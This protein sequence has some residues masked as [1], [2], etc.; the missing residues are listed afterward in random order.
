[1]GIKS[2]IF[3]LFIFCFSSGISLKAQDSGDTLKPLRNLPELQKPTIALGTGMLSFKGDVSSNS[4][5]QNLVNRIAYDLTLSKPL[6]SFLDLNFYILFGKIG[7]NERTASRNLNFQSEIRSGGLTLLYNFDHLLI[8]N[9]KIEPYILFGFEGFEFLSKTDMYDKNGNMYHYWDDGSIRS[10]AQNSPNA[11]KAIVL[12]RDYSYESDIRELDMD[13]FGKYKEASYAI[14]IG[15]GAKMKL[16]DRVNFK[17]GPTFHF[18]MTDYIDGITDLSI[19]DRKGNKRNDVFI[20]TSFSLSYDLVISKGLPAQFEEGAPEQ[21]FEDVDYLALYTADEDIDGVRDFIDKCAGTPPGVKVD[22]YGCPLDEDNDGIPN[23]KDDELTTPKDVFV[24]QN[25][26]ELTDEL[27]EQ[28]YRAYLGYIQPLDYVQN[29]QVKRETI[30]AVQVGVYKD[31]KVP[32]EM[33]D[34]LLNIPDVKSVSLPDNSTAFIV[35]EFKNPNNAENRKNIMQE[36]GIADAKIVEIQINEKTNTTK[37]IPVDENKLAANIMNNING[38][39]NSTANKTNNTTS[40]E[41]KNYAADILNTHSKEVG[42]NALL[43]SSDKVE[44]KVMLGAY[45]KGIPPTLIN[46]FLKVPNIS[47]DK[48]NDSITVYTVGKYN[49]LA[50]AINKQ[51]EITTEGISDAK[52][53]QFINGKYVPIT[54][55]QIADLIRKGDKIDKL[56]TKYLSS[57][58]KQIGSNDLDI[59]EYYD[60]SFAN[61]DPRDVV[62]FRVQLGAYRKKLSRNIFKGVSGVIELT[63]EEKLTKYLTGSFV[64]YNDAARHKIDMLEKGFDDAFIVAYKNG[65]RVPLNT[66]GATNSAP[67]NMEENVPIN[68]VNKDLISYKIEIGT[69]PGDLPADML[70]KLGPL[71]LD[72]EKQITMEGNKRYTVGSFS[73]YMSA[74]IFKNQI[75]K[76]YNLSQVNVIAFFKD[77]MIPLQE[78]LDLTE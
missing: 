37:I 9:R 36:Y 16:S 57:L 63:M 3:I 70:T 51:Y 39:N 32:D 34:K 5:N 23:H 11:A 46:K 60:E 76:K 7:A 40:N 10:I 75:S 65:K 66:V 4:L 31:G 56:P 47:P 52:V 68:A 2:T 22:K 58:D 74:L 41:Y 55:E 54:Q 17:I 8:K 61:L 19:A 78:A 44:Y 1:M 24:T 14:P 69:Y 64:A 21:G 49:D 28:M 33:V 45:T 26:L 53:V 27:I 62:V 38:T 50:T 13:G 35:G 29:M 6:N 12:K 15:L 42:S 30:Y 67:E 71:V 72:I 77:E 20:M 73:D 25:G 18:T 59:K 48:V 43:T